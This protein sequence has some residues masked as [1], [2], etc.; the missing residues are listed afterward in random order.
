MILSDSE[1]NDDEIFEKQCSSKYPRFS[2]QRNPSWKAK[3][4]SK[5]IPKRKRNSGSSL[6]VQSGNTLISSLLAESLIKDKARKK[7]DPMMDVDKYSS[8]DL[9]DD[10]PTESNFDGDDEQSDFYDCSLE[11]QSRHHHHHHRHH[12]QIKQKLE[13]KMPKP[14]NP[15][16][17]DFAETHSPN[18]HWKRRRAMH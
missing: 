1:S 5:I 17:V 13:F 3:E 15:F 18:N 8:S 7:I 9:S 2:K 11:N 16:S 12:S 6:E 4:H 14:V 10:C